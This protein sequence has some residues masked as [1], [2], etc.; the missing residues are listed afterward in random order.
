MHFSNF[1]VAARALAVLLLGLATLVAGKHRF[2][3]QRSGNGFVAT[4][5]A[6]AGHRVVFQRSGSG[7]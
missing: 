2:R 3:V 6:A 5:V 1:R 7:Y 4:D